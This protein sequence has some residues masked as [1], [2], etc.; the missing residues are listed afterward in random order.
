MFTM[1]PLHDRGRPAA[2]KHCAGEVAGDAPQDGLVG[3]LSRRAD[4]HA[5]A[6]VVDEHVEPAGLREHL[7]QEPVP[8]RAVGHIGDERR[9]ADAGGGRIEPGGIPAGDPDAAACGGE[10]RRDAGTVAAGAAGDDD[11]VF[12]R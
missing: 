2:A 6:G 4:L 9:R 5:F 7:R 12:V 3:L 1:S 10:G 8:R 11:R